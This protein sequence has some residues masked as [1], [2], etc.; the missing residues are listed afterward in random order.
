MAD[1]KI[2]DIGE[3]IRNIGKIVD[4]QEIPQPV[5]KDYIIEEGEARCELRLNDNLIKKLETINDFYGLDTCIETAI[6]DMKKYIKDMGIDKDSDL[7]VVVIHV[8]TYHRGRP[9]NRENFYAR[10]YPEFNTLDTGSKW[11]VPE[12]IEKVVW[13]SKN[14]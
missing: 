4:I 6:R 11:E 5:L 12:D 13:S 3:Y 9:T 2:P 1:I 7:E 14:V 8:I 10:G